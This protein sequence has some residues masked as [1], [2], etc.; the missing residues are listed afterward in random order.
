MSSSK[1]Q[2]D[3]HCEAAIA[4]SN[5]INRI[6]SY[7]THPCGLISIILQLCLCHLFK[8]IFNHGFARISII[9]CERFVYFVNPVEY[10]V[11]IF[12]TST[13][14]WRRCYCSG[15][16]NPGGSKITTWMSVQAA[17]FT[18]PAIS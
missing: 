10:A 5:R 1:C 11:M 15:R 4:Y 18:L 8:L 7:H 14:V 9:S 3:G 12:T 16:I 13:F 17:S 2:G 6:R